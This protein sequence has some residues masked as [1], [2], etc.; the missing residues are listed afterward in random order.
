MPRRAR[1]SGAPR[2]Q[3]APSYR[4]LV[5]RDGRLV[6][7][8]LVGD[9]SDALWYADLITAGRTVTGFRRDLAFGRAYA[10]AA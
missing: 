3:G 10:E 1:E 7:A 5:L 2:D 8:V 4:K 6:G 9:T